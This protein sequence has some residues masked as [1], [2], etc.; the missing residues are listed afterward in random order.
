MTII[1]KFDAHF[2]SLASAANKSNVVLER[3]TAATTTHYTKIIKILGTIDVNYA[4]NNSAAAATGTSRNKI[5]RA[6]SLTCE[7]KDKLNR[8][9]TQIKAAV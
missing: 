8:R 2:E 5:T 3:L 4:N 6:P 9:I 7:E 1:E